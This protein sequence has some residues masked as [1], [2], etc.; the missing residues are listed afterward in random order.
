M[1]WRYDSSGNY[2]PA[3]IY[4]LSSILQMLSLII[5]SLLLPLRDVICLD[6][7]SNSGNPAW[8][9]W[10]CEGKTLQICALLELN[11]L[12][13]AQQA[14]HNKL[15]CGFLHNK[16]L[17]GVGGVR[18]WDESRE[19]RFPLLFK[20]ELKYMYWVGAVIKRNGWGD[21]GWEQIWKAVEYGGKAMEHHR[22]IGWNYLF[23][24]RGLLHGCLLH[25]P[26]TDEAYLFRWAFHSAIS[27]PL[28]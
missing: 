28:G 23:I 21:A 10:A 27:P 20:G 17:V 6:S 26:V 24:I 1:L 9:F 7:D 13:I 25:C 4:K 22:R 11:L 19:T 5:F 3:S 16:R 14:L 8:R 12:Q 18:E 2:E 15:S